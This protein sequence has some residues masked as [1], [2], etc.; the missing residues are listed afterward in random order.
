MYHV[1]TYIDKQLVHIFFQ[2]IS[3]YINWSLFLLQDDNGTSTW[4]IFSL[5]CF[6]LKTN[7]LLLICHNVIPSKSTFIVYLFEMGHRTKKIVWFYK[8]IFIVCKKRVLMELRGQRYA[9]SVLENIFSVISR[10]IK[11]ERSWRKFS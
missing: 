4:L 8:E 3:S 9:L 7:L 6:R 1:G 11:S 2:L 5:L 10:V